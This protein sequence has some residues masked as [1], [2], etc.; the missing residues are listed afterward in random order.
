MEEILALFSVYCRRKKITTNNDNNHSNIDVGR[1]ITCTQYKTYIE[2]FNHA[3]SVGDTQGQQVRSY[4]LEC[5][6]NS[7]SVN[8]KFRAY[9]FKPLR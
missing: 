2:T 1:S 9:F 4:E 7:E 5:A 3:E 8:F 6:E